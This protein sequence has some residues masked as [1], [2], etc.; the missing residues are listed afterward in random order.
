M[1]TEQKQKIINLRRIGRSYADIARTVNLPEGTVKSF[2]WRNKTS[3]EP[4]IPKNLCLQC[5]KFLEPQPDAPPRKFC[6]DKCRFDWWRKNRKPNNSAICAGCGK[7]FFYYGKSKRKYCSQEC[8]TKHRFDRS[9]DD[10]E[11]SV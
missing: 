5:G 1:T 8:C 3:P 9:L 11:D 7:E 2:C 6:S 10:R 4:K